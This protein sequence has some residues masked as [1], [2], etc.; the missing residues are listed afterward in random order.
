MS[1]YPPDRPPW[2]LAEHPPED[3][4]ENERRSW[5]INRQDDKRTMT[6]REVIAEEE[7]LLFSLQGP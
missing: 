4:D 1:E 7:D 6:E 5:Y 2:Q 3:Y